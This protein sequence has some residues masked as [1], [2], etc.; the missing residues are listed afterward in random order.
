MILSKASGKDIN[1]QAKIIV[2][3]TGRIRVDT[4]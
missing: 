4:N 2:L 1:I 3:Y